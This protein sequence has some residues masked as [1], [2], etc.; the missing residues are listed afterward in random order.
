MVHL[1][2]KGRVIVGTSEEKDEEEE[3]EEVGVKR[4]YVGAGERP[5]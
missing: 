2:I 1:Q 4:A 5:W 3:E